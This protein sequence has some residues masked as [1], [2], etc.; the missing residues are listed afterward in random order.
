[1]T[2]T[3]LL[4]NFWAAFPAPLQTPPAWPAQERPG[5]IS[6]WECYAGPLPDTLRARGAADWGGFGVDL[7]VL[8]NGAPLLPP[9]DFRAVG[10]SALALAAT[11]DSAD[12][13]CFVYHVAPALPHPWLRLY[14]TAAVPVL[15]PDQV[16][17]AAGLAV[18]VSTA[19]AATD[20][21]ATRLDLSGSKSLSVTVGQGGAVGL[22]AS[23]F[24]NLKGQVAPNVFLEGSL[25]DQNV[26]AQPDGSTANLREIDNKYLRVYGSQYEY[27]LG[28]YLLGYGRDGEDRYVE[29]AEGARLHYTHGGMGVTGEYALSKGVFTSD[30]LRGIDGVQQGYYL[31][32]RDGRTYIT[33][34]AGTE[35][36]WR[37]GVLLRRGT[38]YTI[39]YSQ[40]RIDFLNS[41]WVTGQDLFSAEFQYSEDVYPRSV[42]TTSVDDTV[43]PFRFSAR[44]AQEWDDKDNPTAGPPD[45]ATL[46]RYQNLG[47]SAVLDS[48]GQPIPMPQ[49]LASTAWSAAWQGGEWGN[50]RFTVLGSY[51]DQ[52]LYSHLDDQTD[53]GYSTRYQG[54]NRFGRPIDQGG[55]GRLLLEP[56]HEHRSADFASFHQLVEARSFRDAWNLDAAVG[57]K[58][59]DA[60]KLRLTLEPVT[61]F[62][63]GAEGGLAEGHLGDT[64]A[65]SRRGEV[66]AGLHTARATIDLSSE[67]KLARDPDQRDDYRQ[68]ASAATSWAGW[69]PKLALVRDEWLTAI[70]VGGQSWSDL[71]QPEASL[72]SPTLANRWVWT[73]DV[74]G[75]VGRSNYAGRYRSLRD[76][77]RDVGVSERLRLL[78]WGP[79]SG[80]FFVSRSYHEDWLPDAF[81]ARADDPEEATYDQAEANLTVSAYPKGYG[82]QTHYKVSRTAEVPLVEAYQKVAPG[83]GDYQYDSLLNV[84]QHVETG[85]DYAFIGLRRDSTLG[86]QPYQDLQWSLHVDLSPGRWPLRVG[87]VL[88]DV[89]LGF[90]VQ[91]DAQD[92]SADPVPLPRLTDDEIEAVRSGRASYAPTLRWHS[93][94]TKRSAT[95]RW[96]REYDKGAG[97]SAA[98][99]RSADGSGEY[100]W[101]WSEGWEAALDGDYGVKLSQGLS[102]SD[103]T[104]SE[105]HVQNGSGSISLYRHLSHAFTLIPEFAYAHTLGSDAGAPLDLQSVTPTARV[106]KGSFFG[107]RASLEYSWHY[108]FGVGEGSYFSTGGFLKGS[109]HRIEALAQADL[110]SYL[111]LN[112][113]YLARLDPG[114]AWDQKLSVELRAVF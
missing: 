67:A 7:D 30:T 79:A 107:G 32:G 14:D 40:G 49:K 54:V 57:E 27:L 29:K 43:G 102:D 18:P 37:N 4:L 93:A 111:H 75:Q 51:F 47:D 58:N 17:G 9:Q 88:A 36:I 86:V 33:V 8:R 104:G 96:Q 25:S 6:R 105:S 55:F 26:P 3:P 68:Q 42:V 92:S 11:P 109:T 24:V 20:T 60:N 44:A 64:S 99:Q 31:Y 5:T 56:T 2:W 72:E 114:A 15:R 108:L 78:A 77:L 52:N 53:F 61:G 62:Q 113:S 19:T 81:G 65:D 91:T 100:R 90:D 10:D 73:N 97:L 80:D 23:L 82:M 87:G 70:P 22:D 38:D 74:T 41:F 98:R 48:T 1:M 106:E 63:F 50:G 76:S 89:D 66:F 28:D 69:S 84:Y 112:F 39:D 83:Q 35:R 34:L 13:V 71:W 103:A 46:Q 59:F 85:G 12:T 110:K 21:G 101:Q 94:A 16:P 45:S 95:F